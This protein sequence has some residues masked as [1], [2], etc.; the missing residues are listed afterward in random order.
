MRSIR[1]RRKPK[2]AA[3]FQIKL[4]NIDMARKKPFEDKEYLEELIPIELKKYIVNVSKIC[5]YNE[6]KFGRVVIDFG[7]NCNQEQVC[8]IFR[9]NMHKSIKVS[10]I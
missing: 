10:C 2:K 1:K 4:T 6:H 3:Q 7:Q 8:D 5:R 9:K